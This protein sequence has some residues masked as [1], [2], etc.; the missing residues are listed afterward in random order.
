[1]KKNELN[2]IGKPEFAPNFGLNEK[3]LNQIVGGCFFYSSTDFADISMMAVPESPSCSFTMDACE[4]NCKNC[5]SS[6]I[7]ITVNKCR[8][9]TN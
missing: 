1:M 6:S 7:S 8:S 5:V 4:A 9:R 3:E 2:K